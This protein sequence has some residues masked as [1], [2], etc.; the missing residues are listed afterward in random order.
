MASPDI[1]VIIPVYNVEEYLAECVDSILAARQDL[2]LQIILVDD[3]SKDGSSEIA[4]QYAKEYDF[5]EYHHKE[6][7]GLSSARNFGVTFAKG[8]YIIF[9]DSDDVI[10]DDMLLNMFQSAELY[11]SDFCSCNVVRFNSKKVSPS[12]LHQIM[13]Q[14]LPPK[15]PTSIY[16][17]HRFFYDTISCNKLILRSF[18]QENK[19]QFP[20]GLLFEDI[21]VTLPM[22]LMARRVSFVRKPGYYWRIREGENKSITQNNSNIKNLKDRLTV[23][24]MVY[25]FFDKNGIGD[26]LRKDFDIKVLNLDLVIF[27]NEIKN[28]PPDEAQYLELLRSFIEKRINKQTIKELPV[29]RQQKYDCILTGNIELLKKILD[30][31][32]HETCFVEYTSDKG[33]MMHPH[34]ALYQPC[35]RSARNEFRYKPIRNYIDDICFYDNRIILNTHLYHLRVNI[36][37]WD[38]LKVSAALVHNVTYKKIPLPV[39]QYQTDLMTKSKGKTGYFQYNYD[40]VCFSISISENEL[41]QCVPGEYHILMNYEHPLFSGYEMLHD[42]GDRDKEYCGGILQYADDRYGKLK[43]DKAA[44]LYYSVQERMPDK[45]NKKQNDIIRQ[46]RAETDQNRILPRTPKLPNDNTVKMVQHT[47]KLE[48]DLKADEPVSENL[49]VYYINQYSGNTEILGK[50]SKAGNTEGTFAIDFTKREICSNLYN[51]VRKIFIGDPDTRT[52]MKISF[53]K[54][55]FY[56]YRAESLETVLY[57]DENRNL[58]LWCGPRWSVREDTEKKRKSVYGV[59]RREPIKQK[60]ILFESMWGAKYNC[61]PQALYE[62][63]DRNHPEYTCVWSLVDERMPI[64]GNG[65]R[66]RRGSR[67]YYYYLAKAKYLV[68][69]VNF[70]NDYVKRPEQI[71]IETMHG[72]PFKFFG[73]DTRSEFHTKNEVWEYI[74]RNQNWDCLVTQGAFV[75]KNAWR[76]FRYKGTI[77]E[78]G[79]PRTDSIADVSQEVRISLKKKLGLPTDKKLILYAPTWRI[80]NQFNFEIDFEA[81]RESIGNEYTFMVRVHH[82]AAKKYLLPTDNDFLFDLTSYI[83]IEDLYKIADILITDYSSAMFDF[84]LTEKPMIFYTYDAEDYEERLRGV[85]FDLSKEAP[86][87][88]VFSQEE[89][90]HAILNIEEELERC[91]G[92][93]E[94]FLSKYLTYECENSCKQVFEQVIQP[95]DELTKKK[96]AIQNKKI[97]KL[98]E[99]AWVHTVSYNITKNLPRK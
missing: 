4:Q 32:N 90:I 9:I 73:L 29:D 71:M 12:G 23:L 45:S 74:R 76:M 14:A 18:W 7:G 21:P 22:H 77:L 67:E 27:I 65:I 40:G 58:Y 96:Q 38:K 55:L 17:Q 68:N 31:N 95:R 39:T 87:P 13:F 86:G 72:T 60:C 53:P 10:A 47:G 80:S 92:R 25:Q 36:E 81:L 37:T 84:A 50:F 62:Y 5:I 11:D 34:P 79:Y 97:Q 16:E 6:N 99:K 15:N 1:S 19:L 88:I 66:V 35:L 48:I 56:E 42:A 28:N 3:G 70:E 20:E 2:N 64:N 89:L 78:T 61:N 75:K 44:Y 85:Y 33:Y 51:G 91:A 63:I 83:S 24:E 59:Y 94:A 54:P 93:K 41:A 46:I 98:W 82:L 57:S 49:A 8:K 43:F 69:N 52:A 30:S 26:D